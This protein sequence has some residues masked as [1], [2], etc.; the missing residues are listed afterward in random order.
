MCHIVVSGVPCSGRPAFSL[1]G[2]HGPTLAF[3]VTEMRLRLCMLSGKV[4][5]TPNSSPFQDDS[6][7][8]E[9]ARSYVGFFLFPSFS[10]KESQQKMIIG[11]RGLFD[12]VGLVQFRLTP[13]VPA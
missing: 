10:L 13:V 6:Q 1:K 7:L 2:L 12:P 9:M 11:K 4:P 5:S 8:E 3:L